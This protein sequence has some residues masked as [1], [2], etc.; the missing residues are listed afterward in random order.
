MTWSRWQTPKS[1]GCLLIPEQVSK[2]KR[3]KEA[4]SYHRTKLHWKFTGRVSQ[5]IIK[6]RKREKFRYL[7]CIRSETHTRPKIGPKGHERR[8]RCDNRPT[9]WQENGALWD[10]KRLQGRKK[11]KKNLNWSE[12]NQWDKNIKAA[13]WN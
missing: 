9:G 7:K 10:E 12:K 6:S 5:S 1:D 13:L 2:R 11:D 8:T 3:K 4:M